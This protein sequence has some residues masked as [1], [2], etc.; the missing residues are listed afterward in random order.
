[1]NTYKKY[2]KKYAK[3]PVKMR[4]VLAETV[5]NIKLKLYE[6]KIVIGN[7]SHEVHTVWSIFKDKEASDVISNAAR[8]IMYKIDKIK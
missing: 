6:G 7:D 4:Q 8:G 1:M 5:D 3:D 2:R